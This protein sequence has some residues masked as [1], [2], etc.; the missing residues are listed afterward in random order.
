MQANCSVLGCGDTKQGVII[1][2]GG[3]IDRIKAAVEL[4]DFDIVAILLTHAHLDHI[5]AVPEAKQCFDVQVRLHAGD[6]AL[7]D[8]MPA[9]AAMFGWPPRESV[10]AGEL[11]L[12]ADQI[13]FGNAS[14]RVIHTPGHT[15]GC[16]C[17]LLEDEGKHLLIAGDTLFRRG[18]GRTDLP[19]GNF[20]KLE[21]SIRDR[22]YTLDPKCAVV[23]GHGPN[24]TIGE[25]AAHNPFVRANP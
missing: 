25:E 16:V 19:G 11:F 15:E 20:A 17:F 1:D 3:D 7:Y 21:S 23:P 22:L 9:Q 8:G 6:L 24:T 5:W 18:I 2:P 14:A 13:Q 12:H 4:Y 10:P